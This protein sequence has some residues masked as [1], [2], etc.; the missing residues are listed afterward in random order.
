MRLIETLVWGFQHERTKIFDGG[1]F[2]LVD[3]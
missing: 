2:V 3:G 1:I